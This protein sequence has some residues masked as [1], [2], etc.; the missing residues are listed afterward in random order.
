MKGRGTRL[1]DFKVCWTDKKEI[2][3]TINSIKSSFKLFDYFKNYQYFE[4]EFDYDQRL[5]LPSGGSKGGE[6]P[7]PPIS[8]EVFNKNLDPIKRTE[9]INIPQ[10]GMR[11]DRDL[12][13][14]FKN[15][16]LKD[17]HSYSKL[18]GLVEIQNFE[19][20]EKYLNEKYFKSSYSLEKLRDSLG[21]DVNISIK[22]LL[23]YL[24]GYINKF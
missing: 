18:K 13:K 2:P 20:A 22:E 4:E 15:D 12:Y 3:K 1:F 8:E 10:A 23:L 16:I 5:K 19:E 17:E 21:L 11:I 9:E 24:F 14:S 6:F 7:N